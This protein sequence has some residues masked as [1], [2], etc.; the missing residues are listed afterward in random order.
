MHCLYERITE[1]HCSYLL[2]KRTHLASRFPSSIYFYLIASVNPSSRFCC[3]ICCFLLCPTIRV[4]PSDHRTSWHL[5]LLFYDLSMPLLRILQIP[6]FLLSFEYSP[7]SPLSCTA[8][9]KIS[10]KYKTWVELSNP[11]HSIDQ[12]ILSEK[13]RSL[14][15]QASEVIPT[16][17]L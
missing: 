11:S 4:E 3:C 15:L 6:S 16:I 8:S 1:V 5:P 12:P 2:W 14:I 17:R 13:S 10:T 7:R 9:S